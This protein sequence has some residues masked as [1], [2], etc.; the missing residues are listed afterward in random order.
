MKNTVRVVLALVALMGIGSVNAK[1]VLTETSPI[2]YSVETES[3]SKS[4]SFVFY[5]A[6]GL[7]NVAASFTA[8][9]VDSKPDNTGSFILELFSGSGSNKDSVNGVF[10]QS[11]NTDYSFTANLLSGVKYTLKFTQTS[12]AQSANISIAA[13]PEPE[14]YALMGVG[15]LGL[16]AA[17]RRKSVRVAI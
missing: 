5:L 13:V 2:K 1:T 4:D 17:R 11:N 6:K 15:L 7:T 14:T 10:G 16:L 8:S 9:S 12:L 3:G